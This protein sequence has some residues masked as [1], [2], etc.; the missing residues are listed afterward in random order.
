MEHRDLYRLLS[1][2]II[3]HNVQC[4]LLD[5]PLQA[6]RAGYLGQAFSLTVQEQDM[7]ASIGASDFPSFARYVDRWISGN[8]H[9]GRNGH[10]DGE[11]ESW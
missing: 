11:E 7:L 8:G 5:N 3:D 4:Q 9:N 1:A 6:V 10:G 2:A